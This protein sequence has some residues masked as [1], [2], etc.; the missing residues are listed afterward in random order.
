MRLFS[1][2]P[3]VY[4]ES[5]LVIIEYQNG[6]QFLWGYEESIRVAERV[7]QVLELELQI[8]NYVQRH[9]DECIQDLQSSLGSVGSEDMLNELILEVLSQK[10]RNL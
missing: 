9:F 5:D 8:L 6:K 2:Y 10:I 3:R 7:A 1:S 4:A